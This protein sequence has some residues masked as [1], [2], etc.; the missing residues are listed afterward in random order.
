MVVVVVGVVGTVG[1]VGF[2]GPG[3]GGGNVPSTTKH[4]DRAIL[5]AL[6]Y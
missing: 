1:L 3:V 2:V 6:W 5:V 4:L